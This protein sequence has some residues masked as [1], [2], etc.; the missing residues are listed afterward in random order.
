MVESNVRV[1]VVIHEK[2]AGINEQLLV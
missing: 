1:I 2:N